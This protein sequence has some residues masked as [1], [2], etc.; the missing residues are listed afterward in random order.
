MTQENVM[1][2]IGEEGEWQ[3]FSRGGLGRVKERGRGV[4]RDKGGRKGT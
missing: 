4:M 3:S 1:D 2:K